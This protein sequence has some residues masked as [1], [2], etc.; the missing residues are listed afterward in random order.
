MDRLRRQYRAAEGAIMN[1]DY[2]KP[3]VYLA[4]PGVFRPD[5]KAFGETLKN[6]CERAGLVGCFPLDNE[7]KAD[8][9]RQQAALIY[10]ANVNLIH[11]VHAIIADISPFRGPNMD[12]GTAWEIGYGIAR[13]LPIYAWTSD[14]SHLL[15]RTHRHDQGLGDLR[16]VN[17][18][19][20]ENFDLIE[21]LMIAVSAASIHDSADASIAAC[22]AEVRKGD[23]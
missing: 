3:R 23:A 22:A 11:S 14:P 8:T 17:G 5:A 21:N 4:G 6:K 2:Q 12:P 15:E 1:K 18:W 10:R 20:I 16:D 7:I 13:G 9:P 19:I